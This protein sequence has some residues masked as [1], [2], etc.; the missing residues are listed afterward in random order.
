[1][2]FICGA[3][4]NSSADGTVRSTANA[5][6][7]YFGMRLKHLY[8]AAFLLFLAVP[9]CK[10]EEK[11]GI[12]PS[13][14]PPTDVSYDE[15]NSSS[16]A[17]GFYWEVDDAV[18]A[19][20][21]SFTAQIVKDHELGADV[22]KG[23]K[24][25]TLQASASPNDGI[26]FNGL[27]ENS[28]FYARV[29]ANYPRS[30]YSEWV[31]VTNDAGERAVIKLGR[32]IVDESIQAV[33]GAS[34]RLVDLSPTTAVVE[35]SV[36]DFSNP[37]I[38]RAAEST[39]YLYSD[40]D[41]SNIVVSWDMT[42]ASLYSGQPRFIFSSL[43]PGTPYW[44]V[45]KS[46]TLTEDGE[47]VTF[48]SEPVSFTT[49]Q[50]KAVY[51]TTGTAQPGETIIFQDFSELIWGG[52]AVN[53][54]VGY[55]AEKRSSVT[56]L[57]AAR[58]WNPVGG[59]YGF[60]LCSPA[61][62]MGLYN[63]IQKA[64]A[65]SSTTLSKWAELREDPSVVGMVCGRPGSVKVGASS[66]VGA[67]VTPQ[68]SVLSGVATVELRFKASPYGGSNQSLD[69]LGT[70]VRL[71][72]GAS[73]SS[74]IVTSA[75]S[76]I[77]VEKFNLRNDLALSEYVVTVHNVTPTSRLAIG[78]YREDGE[79]GQHRLVLDDISVKVISYG[80]T[81]F[82][83]DTPVIQ[84]SAGEGQI[85]VDWEACGNATS[86]DVE[87]KKT[88]DSSWRKAGN[89]TYNTFT[90]RSLMPEVSYDV[91]VKAK[92]SEKYTSEWSEV[93]GITTPKVNKSITISAPYVTAAAI[94][95]KWYTDSN[96]AADIITGYRLELYKGSDLV[97]RLSLG[98]NGVPDTAEMTVASSDM[99]SLWTAS[100][101]A[102]FL[103]A[104]LEPSTA[105]R[106]VV[107]NKDLNIQ[108]DMEVTTLPSS[109]VVPPSSPASAGQTILFEDFSE[110]IWGGLPAL[111]DC[112]YGFPGFSSSNRSSRTTFI[113][114]RGEQP[115]ANS[116]DKLYLAA[117][118][119][120]YGLL[121]TTWRATAATRLGAW[122]AISESYSG[123]AAGSL[124][125][126]PGM[127]KL[128]A[129]NAWCQILTPA[130]SC[131]SGTATLKVSFL[132]APYT[133]NGVKA[134]DPLDAVVKVYDG[135]TLAKTGDMYQAFTSGTASYEKTFTLT[136]RMAFQKY[137]FTI[138]GVKPGARIAI[139][140]YR[141]DSSSGQRRAFL[142][143][144]KVEI[145]NYQ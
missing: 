120:Q 101:G 145:V 107:T 124:C 109:V 89:T 36:T 1:M 12:D 91:R 80:E 126:M 26:V 17:L 79:T 31:Y 8:F 55:S 78:G 119:T 75:S 100:T 2:T 110:L 49:E 96:Y 105:Y 90:I 133:D 73:V 3:I 82:T 5:L 130:L 45:V 67:L 18:A 4:R 15:V 10:Q 144:V 102:C 112:D 72:D 132:M 56:S 19:G 95:F 127:V 38:D 21:V 71:L 81:A 103:F 137:E 13:A 43:T 135:V 48:R 128:G 52:D 33:T 59:D 97:T 54:A 58:G 20:A 123:G 40:A 106:L 30:V 122:G 68:L 118:G 83:V 134:S 87:Y 117:A 42:D 32:G 129:S 34:A 131:L 88:S 24:S 86:Y 9:S 14:V 50:A 138:P 61:T 69:P 99:P 16:T 28:K 65:G 93:V 116:S 64:L 7:F 85:R 92:Y 53:K 62:E 94:G 125:G 140:T 98:E 84:L 74:N 51:K 39:I 142:D 63:S 114:L 6:F 108:A 141:K 46:K 25:Q 23:D 136:D 47:E 113:P 143:D 77:V 37:V 60:Y 66:K 29:R 76:N 35:W 27:S 57:K 70:C 115:L 22:Y 121:N 11:V 41:C 44:F 104:G 111:Q 139:G